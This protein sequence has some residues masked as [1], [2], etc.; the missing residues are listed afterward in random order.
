MP[1][2]AGI[3]PRSDDA[4]DSR[5]SVVA[6]DA[7]LAVKLPPAKRSQVPFGTEIQSFP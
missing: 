1:V 6:V 7:Y 3:V 4:L 5:M 2:T